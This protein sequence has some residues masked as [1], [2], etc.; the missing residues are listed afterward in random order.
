VIASLNRVLLRG[1][2]SQAE[3]AAEIAS[4]EIMCSQ[5]RLIV[6]SELV[7][8]EKVEKLAE[9]QARLRAREI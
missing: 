2:G 6:G 1:H 7:D 4:V 3:V 9:L 8:I 5:L